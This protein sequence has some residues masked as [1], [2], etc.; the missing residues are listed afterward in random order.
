M[1][2]R[3]S[4]NN[5]QLTKQFKENTQW[6]YINQL[7]VTSLFVLSYCLI[8]VSQRKGFVLINNL[9]FFSTNERR[10]NNTRMESLYLRFGVVVTTASGVSVCVSSFSYVCGACPCSTTTPGRSWNIAL[11]FHPGLLTHRPLR[12]FANRARWDSRL[13]LTFILII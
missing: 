6:Q 1:V 11:H 7:N 5:P 12:H 2:S 3:T 10:D 8:L 13:D 4:N 9:R